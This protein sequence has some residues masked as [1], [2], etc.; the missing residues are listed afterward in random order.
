MLIQPDP[1]YKIH[2][3][4]VNN[5]D[6]L[7]VNPVGANNT[8]NVQSNTGHTVINRDLGGDTYNVS[9]NAPTDT[10]VLLDHPLSRVP[11][12]LFGQLDLHAGPGPN[13]LTVSESTTTD[14]DHM[15]I[16]ASQI[17]GALDS[18]DPISRHPVHMK[19]QINYDAL[20]NFG[21]GINI[22]TGT[23]ADFLSVTSLP[24][25]A[26][27]LMNTGGGGDTILVGD[28]LHGLDNI[29]SPLFLSGADHTSNLT[30]NDQATAQAEPYLL[31]ASPV[32]GTILERTGSLITYGAMRSATLEAGTPA[33][34]IDVQSIGDSATIIVPGAGTTAVGVGDK[35]GNFILSIGAQLTVDDGP[36]HPTLTLNDQ[37]DPFPTT[38]SLNAASL[39]IPGQAPII[40]VGLHSVVLN[41]GTANDTYNVSGAGDGTPITINAGPGN[42][43]FNLQVGLPT[44]AAPLQIDGGPGD[45]KLSLVDTEG[46]GIVRTIPSTTDPTSGTITV[47]YPGSIPM[48]TVNYKHVASVD[49]VSNVTRRVKTQI[50]PIFGSPPTTPAFGVTVTN[51]SSQDING[52]IR[53][54]VAGL[55]PKVAL[56]KVLFGASTLAIRKDAFGDPFFSISVGKL[57]S[58]QSLRLGLV[59][60]DPLG[61]S[62]KFA[63]GVFAESLGP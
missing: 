60:A 43:T 23:G 32:F 3:A 57:R 54:V 38:Y 47:T 12:G 31:R 4:V 1:H 2:A 34:T 33:N 37:G 53:I 20:G 15:V 24:P 36:T 14:P 41:G 59:F 28:P 50:V 63:L 8:I 17:T 61:L 40:F 7:F 30:I 52:N 42:D 27:T 6:T 19:Y 9:S 25:K 13:A 45:D 44:V 55:S 11:F 16:T 39:K 29:R 49:A 10:G 48:A 56:T 21:N 62:L 35:A 46:I 22:K 26:L 58:G 18:F 51:I 5:E